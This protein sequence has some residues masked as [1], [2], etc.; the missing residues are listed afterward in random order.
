[1]SSMQSVKGRYQHQMKS[2]TSRIRK[3]QIRTV[4]VRMRVGERPASTE[5][6]HSKV[7]PRAPRALRAPRV[8]RALRA[9]LTMDKAH[10]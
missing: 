9:P 2:N 4:R 8:L 10:K 7:V 5:L 6:W 1:M 3:H